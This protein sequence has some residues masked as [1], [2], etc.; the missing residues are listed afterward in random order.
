MQAESETRRSH[1][2]AGRGGAPGRG[3]PSGSQAA[4]AAAAGRAA[5]APAPRSQSTGRLFGWPLPGGVVTSEFGYRIHPITGTRRLHAGIDIATPC[6][7]PIVAALDGEIISAGW[8]AAMAIAWSSTTASSGVPV[9]TSYNHAADCRERWPRHARLA[10]IGWGRPA[11]A[12]AVTCTSRPMSTAIPSIRVAGSRR[13]FA[14]SVCPCRVA[15]P[16]DEGRTDGQGNRSQGGR[17]QPQG[18]PRLS[19]RGHLRS[20]HQPA[21]TEVRRCAWAGPRSLTGGPR[22]VV[23]SS[24]SK[25]STSPSTTTA[26]NNHTRDASAKLLLH[27][28][29]LDKLMIKTRESGHTLVPLQLYFKDGAPRWRSRSQG[30]KDYDKAARAARAPGPA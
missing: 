10:V 26:R 6:G 11:S 28:R 27:R 15:L 24:G 3:S 25:A 7:Q 16:L 14:Q 5:A 8:G 1:P 29:E 12:R 13:P 17:E 9:A 19:H 20:G 23:T 30:K 22:S 18:A 21:G 4:A 2:A